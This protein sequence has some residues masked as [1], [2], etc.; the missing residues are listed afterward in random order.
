MSTYEID[1]A[2]EWRLDDAGRGQTI[3]PETEDDEYEEDLP[4]REKEVDSILN[5]TIRPKQRGGAGDLPMDLLIWGDAAQVQEACHALDEWI[6]RSE[7]SIPAMVSRKAMPSVHPITTKQKKSYEAQLLERTQKDLFRQTPEKGIN[8]AVTGSYLWCLVEKPSKVFGSSYEA[9]DPI[10]MFHGC[11]IIY[12]E[13]VS[14][15]KVLA[16]ATIHVEGAINSIANLL[17]E[18]ATRKSAVV[19]KYLVDP[20]DL[21]TV[22]AAVEVV[23][24]S[25]S[26][27]PSSERVEK[28]PRLTG[29]SLT[30]VELE[31][32]QAYSKSLTQDNQ[33]TMQQAIVRQILRLRYFRGRIQMRAHMGIFALNN[34]RWLPNNLSSVSLKWFIENLKMPGTKGTLHQVRTMGRESHEMIVRTREAVHLFEPVDAQ[35]PELVDVIP[36]YSALFLFGPN[37][38]RQIKLQ[39]DTSPVFGIYGVHEVTHR[40][41]LETNLEIGPPLQ[42]FNI[43]LQGGI[44]WKLQIAA[45]N[46]V[47]TSRVTPS[48]SK[49]ASGIRYEVQNRIPNS[50]EPS[51]AVFWF[52][53]TPG[54]LS[55]VQKT[56]WRYRLRAHGSYVFEVA[57][58]DTFHVRD[59]RLLNTVWGGS[60]HNESWDQMLSTNATMRSGAV[61]SWVPSQ[62]VF[63]PPKVQ[64]NVGEHEAGFA[65]FLTT[66]QSIVNFLN[67]ENLK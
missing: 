62:E 66:L 1:D 58:Y 37:S 40:K 21:D 27:R 10:R 44:S 28:L 17:C 20:P 32:W 14:T 54:L 49:F 26:D 57:R 13:T 53:L 56:V 61:A 30:Q 63:F 11:Y 55:F 4:V 23:D 9:L 60:I 39:I 52:D 47:E 22:R 35:T 67:K 59:R 29:E 7:F 51:K 16:N 43:R 41:W 46:N 8:F 48:M 24:T 5:W 15:F 50:T 64:R 2:R 25:F 34:F 45:E 3:E 19:E 33:K 38:G 6:K 65:D 12:D 36:F 31:G 42:I 18:Y